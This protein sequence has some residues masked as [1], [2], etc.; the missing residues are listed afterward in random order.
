MNAFRMPFGEMTISL[1]N[2]SCLLGLPVT[3]K[4]VC[5]PKSLDPP[6]PVEL[7]VTSLSASHSE[8][9]DELNTKGGALG[10]LA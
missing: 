4:S 10:V 8:A 6:F 3:G 9:R 7:L 5:M 2:V 1:D